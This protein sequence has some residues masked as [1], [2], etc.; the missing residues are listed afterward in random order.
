MQKKKIITRLNNKYLFQ[1]NR[2]EN[3]ELFW[4]F[5]LKSLLQ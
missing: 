2:F 1:R 3:G 5:T 4:I